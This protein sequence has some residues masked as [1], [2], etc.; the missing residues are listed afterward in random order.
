MEAKLV[1]NGVDFAPWCK[2]GGIQQ[3]Y[4]IRR[5]REVV[6]TDGTVYRK[7][8][9]KRQLTVSLVEMR[10][11]TADG[12][13]MPP[14][15]LAALRASPGRVT[16]TDAEYGEQLKLFLISSPQETAKTV[17]GGNTYWSG[18]SFTMEEK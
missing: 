18:I 14:V 7:E 4:A 5:S 8:I 3:Q 11:A 17:T 16:Y 10:D 13:T 6:A 12:N 9:K 2:S 15:L 1:I